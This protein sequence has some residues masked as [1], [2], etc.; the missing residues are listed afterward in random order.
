MKLTALRLANMIDMRDAPVMV[1]T[2]DT[3]DQDEPNIRRSRQVAEIIPLFADRAS[4]I[5]LVR[6]R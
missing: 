4:A 3:D 2:F 6:V 1:A 5:K